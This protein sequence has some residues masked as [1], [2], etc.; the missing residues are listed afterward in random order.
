M[1]V[2]LNCPHCDSNVTVIHQL[3][4][5]KK[6]GEKGY[7]VYVECYNCL[8]RGPWSW[9]NREFYDHGQRE[10]KAIEEWNRREKGTAR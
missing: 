5:P 3:F 6:N 4:A 10:Q 1:T 8:S 2:P 9:L 7:D